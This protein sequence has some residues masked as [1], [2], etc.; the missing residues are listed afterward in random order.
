MRL[1]ARYANAV[2]VQGPVASVAGH[3]AYLHECIA[4]ISG[5]SIDDVKVT[6]LGPVLIGHDDADLA[7]RVAQSRGRVGDQRYRASVNAGTVDDQVTRLSA[8][9]DV[10]VQ[11]AIVSLIGLGEPGALGPLGRMIDRLRP[12]RHR[13]SLEGG[14]L[15]GRTVDAASSSG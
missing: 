6:H 7:E 5:R 2:N 10:G 1:A 4:A 14:L 3:V 8:L 9:A 15:L 12:Q 13:S 11:T